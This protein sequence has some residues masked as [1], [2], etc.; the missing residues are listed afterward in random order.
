MAGKQQSR[1]ESARRKRFHFDA[2]GRRGE[3]A[4]GRQMEDLRGLT[5]F[6][7]N[8]KIGGIA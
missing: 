7:Y 4:V 6:I 8:Y 3:R 5:V 1:A 2:L